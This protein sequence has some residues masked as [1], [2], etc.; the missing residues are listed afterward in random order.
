MAPEI[1]QLIAHQF[2][3]Q[4]KYVVQLARSGL[5]PIEVNGKSS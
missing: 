5:A 3:S 2:N 4:K 1:K